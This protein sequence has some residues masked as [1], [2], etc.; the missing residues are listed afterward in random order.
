MLMCLSFFPEYDIGGLKDFKQE[1][2]I[3]IFSILENFFSRCIEKNR[4]NKVCTGIGRNLLSI[5]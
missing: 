3:I 1:N 5:L 4:L 2:G